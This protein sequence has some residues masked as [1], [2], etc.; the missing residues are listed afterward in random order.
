MVLEFGASGRAGVEQVGEQSDGLQAMG[1]SVCVG[2][3]VGD[4]ALKREG[5]QEKEEGLI[6]REDN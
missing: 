1:T 4:M 6:C 5:H 2:G 3:G